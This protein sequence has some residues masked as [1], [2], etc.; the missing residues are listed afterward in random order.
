MCIYMY[1]Y[2]VVC[3]NRGTPKVLDVVAGIAGMA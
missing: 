1:I 3:Q 2:M